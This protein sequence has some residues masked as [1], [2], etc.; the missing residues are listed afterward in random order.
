MHSHK[1]QG[2]PADSNLDEVYGISEGNVIL[3]VFVG[4]KVSHF[5]KITN[6]VELCVH[7]NYEI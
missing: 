6:R 7:E 4:E 1:H 3:A 5:L 2:I